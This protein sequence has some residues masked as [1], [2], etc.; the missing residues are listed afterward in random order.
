MKTRKPKRKGVKKKMGTSSEQES[1][2]TPAERL[3]EVRAEILEHR[4]ALEEL[5]KEKQSLKATL[6]GVSQE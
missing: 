2:K 6:K 4:K 3:E 5:R 1:V